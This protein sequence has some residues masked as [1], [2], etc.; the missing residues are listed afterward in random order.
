M[1]D[2]RQ[3]TPTNVHSGHQDYKRLPPESAIGYDQPPLNGYD[4]PTTTIKEPPRAPITTMDERPQLATTI[5][6]HGAN[7]QF[8]ETATSAHGL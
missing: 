2:G 8:R 7:H 5:K 4:P 1:I 3:Q 6:G